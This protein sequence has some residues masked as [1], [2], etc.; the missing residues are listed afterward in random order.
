[1]PNEFALVADRSGVL[2]I[3]GHPGFPIRGYEYSNITALL[4]YLADVKADGS[5]ENW[6]ATDGEV[7][8]Y[9][10]GSRTTGYRL[11]QVRHAKA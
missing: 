1:M 6:K 8:S 2:R 11:N 3:Y 7:A 10:Y 4:N 9:I 5:P